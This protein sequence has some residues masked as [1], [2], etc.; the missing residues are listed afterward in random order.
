MIARAW[1]E[2]GFS[3]FELELWRTIDQPNPPTL[4]LPNW[5]G[6][7]RFKREQAIR[8]DASYLGNVPSRRTITVRR[9]TRFEDLESDET[10][11]GA[12]EANAAAIPLADC[13]W[14]RFVDQNTLYVRLCRYAHEQGCD[15]IGFSAADVR[16]LL[17]G[18]ARELMVRADAEFH[19][20]DSW[21]VRRR[22]EDAVFDLLKGAFDRIYRCA[23]SKRGRRTT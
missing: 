22:W 4:H 1:T 14:F 17:N 18:Q 9:E 2:A 8:L 6:E 12:V 20:P 15:N 10:R 11:A 3:E 21:F 13:L 19:R 16:A 23:R 5:P 7:E